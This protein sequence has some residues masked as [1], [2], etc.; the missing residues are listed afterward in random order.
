MEE[1]QVL[2]K[3]GELLSGLTAK[4]GNVGLDAPAA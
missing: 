2:R 4:A 3:I 1:A